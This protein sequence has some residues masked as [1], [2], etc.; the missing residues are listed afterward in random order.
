MGEDEKDLVLGTF[1]VILSLIMWR[2]THEFLGWAVLF[3]P[4]SFYVLRGI[5]RLF[6]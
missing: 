1:V 4:G 2:L 3:W 5:W 6:R